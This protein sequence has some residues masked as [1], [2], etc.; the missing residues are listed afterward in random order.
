MF[1]I[2]FL[3]D[4]QKN[5]QELND[6]KLHI[7]RLQEADRK[8]KRKL[9]DEEAIRKIKKLEESI[10]ELRK[11]VIAQKQ[12]LTKVSIHWGGV[13]GLSQVTSIVRER[14]LRLYGHVAR[15]PAEDP[16]HRVL[17]CRDR[18]GWS[19]PRGRPHASWLRQV[20]SYLKDAGMAGLASA[21]AMARRRPI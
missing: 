7:R 18:R 6:L 17:S 21:W 14:Q 15:L 3:V 12:V 10:A 2:Q 8:E 1:I 4:E 19:V 20:E 11:N 13:L 9:A 16:D 5:R